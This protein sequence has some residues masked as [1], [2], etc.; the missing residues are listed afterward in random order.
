MI[1]SFKYIL[2]SFGMGTESI[3]ALLLIECLSTDFGKKS[4]WSSLFIR[5]PGCGLRPVQNSTFKDLKRKWKGGGGDV[6]EQNG[7]Q[8]SRNRST[9]SWSCTLAFC[10]PRTRRSCQRRGRTTNSCRTWPACAL[11]RRTKRSSATYRKLHQVHG[12]V[13]GD[14]IHK[15]T[16]NTVVPAV[17]TKRTVHCSSWIE[18]KVDA[19]RGAGPW[20]GRGVARE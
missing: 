8:P 16:A 12:V 3:F 4:H 15:E 11:S 6:W 18:F 17:R 2:H 9:R 13:Q 1:Y 7:T 20:P 10:W 5:H 19:H 14:V